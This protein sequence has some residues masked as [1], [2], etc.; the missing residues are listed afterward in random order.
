MSIKEQI[1]KDFIN[2]YKNREKSV[3]LFKMLKSAIKNAE[4]EKRKTLSDEEIIAVLQKEKKQREDSIIEFEKGNRPDLVAKEKSEIEIIN[5]YLP[6]QLNE[7]EIKAIV[8]KTIKE[9]GALS[10][11]DFPKVMGKIMPQIKGRAEGSQ[12]AEI[13]KK[14]LNQ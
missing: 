14:Q 5:K 6:K 2:A 11:S 10:M 8:S 12:V 4:I 3:D 7:L 1:E 9:V 13:V